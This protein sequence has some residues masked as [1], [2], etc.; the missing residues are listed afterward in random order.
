[1]EIKLPALPENISP[2]GR[3]VWDWASR[4]S[5]ATQKAHEIRELQSKIRR[6]QNECG[7]CSL[8]MTSSC[9]REVHDNRRGRSSGPSCSA[10]KCSNFIMDSSHAT[11]IQSATIRLEELTIPA[12]ANTESEE[13]HGL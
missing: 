9:P 4:L 12:A 7:S 11:M 13:G 8:W 1:M 2:D 3:E 6:M 5:D 10:I